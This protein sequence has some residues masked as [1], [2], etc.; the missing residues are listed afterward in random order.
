MEEYNLKILLT[1]Y[2]RLE[3][4]RFLYAAFTRQTLV[5]NSDTIQ[6]FFSIYNL[7]NSGKTH[8]TS[9]GVTPVNMP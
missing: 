8:C 7:G 6:S 3:F 5:W 9:C 1:L 2:I 4:V